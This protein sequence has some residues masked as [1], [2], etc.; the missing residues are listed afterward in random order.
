MAFESSVRDQMLAAIPHLRA[1]AMSLTNDSIAADDLVQETLLRAWAN[2]SQFEIGTNLSAWLFTIL[3]NNFYTMKRK[4]QREVADVDGEYSGRVPVHAQQG[5]Y[6]D[7]QDLWAA[8]QKLPPRQREVVVLIGTEGM[9]YEETARICG[10]AVGTIKSRL[11]RARQN[12]AKLLHL[13]ER[14]EIGP[15]EV[16]MAV[17][18]LAA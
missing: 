10:C 15:D 7:L 1:F 2:Q 6:L 13:D 11:C 18:Q 9:S 16:T 4:G 12:L 8:L 17:L 3:R 14:D 5:G